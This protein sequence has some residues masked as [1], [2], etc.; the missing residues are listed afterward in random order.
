MCPEKAF[1]LFILKMAEGRKTAY[2]YPL[3]LRD[4][5]KKIANVRIFI[6]ENLNL[7]KISPI[8]VVKII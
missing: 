1:S 8:C 7:S 2:G 4:L 5:T 3:F 6:S